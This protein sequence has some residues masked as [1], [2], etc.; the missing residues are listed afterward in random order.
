MARILIV[1]DELGM[2][3]TTN[4]FLKNAGYETH[5]AE[6]GKVAWDYLTREGS[7]SE[8]KVDLVLTDHLMP[9][10]DGLELT[11]RIRAD[12]GLSGLKIIIYSGGTTNKEE[13]LV[14]CADGFLEKPVGKATLL[15][16]VGKYFS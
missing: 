1:D 4:A 8:G 12:E 2:R 3:V 15:E 13:A 5:V 16:T 11:R 9:I 14:A 10:M 6:D 7:T